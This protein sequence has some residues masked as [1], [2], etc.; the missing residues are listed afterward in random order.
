MRAIHTSRGEAERMGAMALFGEKYGDGVR[1]VEV[2][3]V[4]RELCGAPT[5]QH[6]RDRALQALRRRI[7]R[8]ERAADRGPH[9]AGGDDQLPRARA[10]AR[11]RSPSGSARRRTPRRRPSGAERLAELGGSR[12]ARLRL[13]G[14]RQGMRREIDGRHGPAVGEDHRLRRRRAETPTS[15]PLLELADRIKQRAGD[16]AV[17]LGGT[18]SRA[19]STLVASFSDAAVSQG[20][21][22]GVERA[23]RRRAKLVGGGG[24][25]RDDVAQAGGQRPRRSSAMRWRRP[26]EAIEAQARLTPGRDAHARA[27]LRHA[28]AAAARSATRSGTVA[29]PARSRSPPE[30]PP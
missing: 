28:P 8:R 29:T 14:P 5:C 1:M 27:R 16:A 25:G 21:V 12:A 3:D 6:G 30:P 15:R 7:Q 26:D 22:G 19:R 24:G 11:A 4:W 13:R 23:S 18:S 17:V 20:A 9:R 2:E 10:R